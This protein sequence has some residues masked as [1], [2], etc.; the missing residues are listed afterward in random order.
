M[1]CC[2]QEEG[3]GDLTIRKFN[4]VCPCFY[5]NYV[6]PSQRKVMIASQLLDTFAQHEM[7]VLYH[8]NSLNTQEWNGIRFKLSEN[9]IRVKVFPSKISIKALKGTA[10]S[11]I[12]P[13]F[14]GCT[15]VAY[16]REPTAVKELLAVTK[17]EDKL[18]LLGGVVEKQILTPV[19]LRDYAALPPLEV[20]QQAIVNTINQV[21]LT[22]I[23]YIE[24]V[25]QRLSQL[26]AQIEK[27]D[28]NET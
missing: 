15:A 1:L 6:Q 16:A 26:M 3:G 8:Y 11:N 9:G 20:V 12:T 13:L 17:S 22:L 28:A 18:Y 7:V 4:Y 23:R 5:Y 2:L 24:S 21:P 10:Y 25:P 19:C 14:R 27:R